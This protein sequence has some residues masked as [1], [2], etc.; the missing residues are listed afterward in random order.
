MNNHTTSI[1]DLPIK[2]RQD[3]QLEVSVYQKSICE[4][5]K[6]TETPITIAIQGQWG[7]GK[8]SFMNGLQEELCNQPDSPYYSIWVNVWHYSLMKDPTETLMKVISAIIADVGEIVEKEHPEAAV[9]IKKVQDVGKKVFMGLTKFAVTAAASHLAQGDTSALTD[10]FS[11]DASPTIADLRHELENVINECVKGSDETPSSKRGFLLFID[12]LDRVDPTVAVIIL[13]LFKNIFDL[14]HCIFVLAIDYDVVVKGLK[15]KFGELTEKNEREFR[16]FFDKIIQLPFQMP[17][18]NYVI[19]KFVRDSLIKIRFIDG[20]FNGEDFSDKI[21]EFINLSVGSNPRSLKRLFNTL[22]L[23]TLIIRSKLKKSDFKRDEKLIGFGLVCL[24]ITYP[25]IYNLLAD[26]PKFTSW[27]E[28]FAQKLKLPIIDSTIVEQLKNYRE[29][30]EEWERILFRACIKDPYLANRGFSISKLLNLFR[31]VTQGDDT[32]LGQII[33]SILEFSSITQV[34]ASEK[35]D[36]SINKANLLNAINNKLL[37][38]LKIKLKSPY[39]NIEQ[40]G[41]RVQTTLRYKFSKN[42][43]EDI[44]ELGL[45]V[46]GSVIILSVGREMPLVK[47]EHT[48]AKIDIES[49]D[50]RKQ[51]FDEII[52]SYEQI[53]QSY[54]KFYCE[55]IPNECLITGKSSMHRLDIHYKMEVVNK[56]EILYD[57]SIEKLA[58]LIT[59]FMQAWVLVKKMQNTS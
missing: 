59:D 17:I 8:T 16:S 58:K 24:Q 19:D 48:D 31:D 29:F 37:P 32:K 22:S 39:K 44:I 26:K 27:N 49:S 12:D 30:D 43:W 36:V 38:S 14:P 25:K 9:S 55:G 23:I 15:P 46:K 54:D 18:N 21:I 11:K 2:G 47:K 40:Q 7:S 20:E 10:I 50:N 1:I 3:D 41:T 51:L 53:N 45:D 56:Y 34:E 52:K 28:E 6:Y 4:F 57:T 5:I 13:E 42:D 35:S 33:E